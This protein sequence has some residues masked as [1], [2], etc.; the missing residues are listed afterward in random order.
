M[1]DLFD[2][3]LE[4]LDYEEHHYQVKIMG[5]I[6]LTYAT[7]GSLAVTVIVGVGS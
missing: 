5:I 1:N 2:E 6:P 4:A 7:I 3:E